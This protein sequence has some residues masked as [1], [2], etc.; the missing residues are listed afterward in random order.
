MR[1]RRDDAP[2]EPTS[3]SLGVH[4]LLLQRVALSLELGC[5]ELV[6]GWNTDGQLRKTDK[7]RRVMSICPSKGYLG[8]QRGPVYEEGL[9][10][11]WMTPWR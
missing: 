1:K 11:R 7:G 5:L 4:L 3:T 6:G 2:V 10:N 9:Q 8:C